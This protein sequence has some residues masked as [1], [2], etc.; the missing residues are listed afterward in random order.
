MKNNKVYISLSADLIHPGHL[1]IIK[2]GSE[3]GEVIIGLL[4]DNAI[5]EFKRIPHMTYEQRKIIVENIKG[6][7][8]VIA[9]DTLDYTK[10]L[11]K[12]KPL[13]VVHGDDWKTGVQVETR[14]KVIN[15]L[16]KWN[17]KLIE[18]P[19]TKNISSSMYYEA[20][21]DLGIGPETRV[22]KL[23]RL[24]SVK[25]TLRFIE[26]HN[27]LTGLIA[28]KTQI[29]KKNK[30]KEFDGI[31]ISSFT[32][33]TSRGMPDI[34][35]L[36]FT[37]RSSTLQNIIEVTTKPII[38]DADTGGKPEHFQFTVKSLERLGVS[39]VIIEDKV[40]L[41]K[42]SLL[43][44][45]VIQKLDS[46]SNF[47][48]K[49]IA[50]KNSKLHNEFMIIARIESFIVG[51]N[52][53]DAIKRAKAYIKAGA[54]GIMIHSKNKTPD[55]IIDFCR[56]YNLLKNKVPLIVVPTT[57][58]NIKESELSKNGVSIIIYANQLLRSAYPAMINAAHSILKN[59]RSYEIDAKLLP[60]KDMLDLIPGTR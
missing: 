34:E 56:N 24:L 49:I 38:Y 32:D 10:N 9:Q 59:E 39:A 25:K 7:S 8:E 36:D 11:L 30:I 48:K 50:G 15:C 19:Y 52:L 58:N 26:A 5:A 12:I 57:Y 41:K 44:N 22:K 43:G 4:T 2:K 28:E 60:I 35:A 51:K 55:Q 3:L 33:S 40:G 14:N 27:G 16:K 13:F 6:V 17:A 23:N 47:S 31:W 20:L 18:I 37:S 53:D 1:N 29:I 45:D 21:K 54:D 46:I 42:N